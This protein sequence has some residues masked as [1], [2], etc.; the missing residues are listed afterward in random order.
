VCQLECPVGAIFS[1]DALPAG[2][3]HFKR[4]NAVLAKQWPVITEKK[5]PPTDAK[6]WE[7]KP[8]KFTLLER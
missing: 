6:D 5:E 8:D 3:E 7:G 1:D 2:Q 4:L